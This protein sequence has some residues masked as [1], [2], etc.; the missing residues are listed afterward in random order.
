M[1]YLK[2]L[3]ELF[4]A[5]PLNVS[6]LL[7]SLRKSSFSHGLVKELACIAAPALNFSLA[8]IS[9][10]PFYN[11]DLEAVG[12]APA[13][14]TRLR[15]TIMSDDAVL[16]VSSE[17]NGS[18]PAALKNAIDVLS[19]GSGINAIMGKP[20][21]VMTASTPATDGLSAGHRLRQILVSAGAR[22]MHGHEVHFID[23]YT[24]FGESGK[25]NE[26]L[27]TSLGSFA[28]TFHD[29]IIQQEK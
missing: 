5:V 2:I 9:D 22:V 20:V 6:V 26:S 13:T 12:P 14:W 25:L 29:W 16:F 19:C 1:L 21:A 23:A 15:N 11:E 4:M 17:H 27:R 10:L 18:L 24:A 3:M 8:A 28:H 7:G